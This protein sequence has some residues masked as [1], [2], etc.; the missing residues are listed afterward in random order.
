VGGGGAGGGRGGARR[1][2]SEVDIGGGGGTR[3]VD[4]LLTFL[5]SSIDMIFLFARLVI[6]KKTYA[7]F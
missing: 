4:A 1:E 7:L 6:R 5:R 3:S 2:M